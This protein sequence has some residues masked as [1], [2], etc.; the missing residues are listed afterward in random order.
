MARLV[1]WWA[2]RTLMLHRGNVT[3][4]LAAWQAVKAQ[5]AAVFATKLG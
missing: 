3:G 2:S 1:S 4:N 5:L